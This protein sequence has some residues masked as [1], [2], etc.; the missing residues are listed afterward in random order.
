MNIGGHL[1]TKEGF[2]KL[3]DNAH[4]LGL[5]TYQFFSKNQMQWKARPLDKEE[6]SAHVKAA[7]QAGINDESIHASYLLNLGSPEEDKYK[8]SYGAF[9]EEI[10]RTDQLGVPLLIFHPG[11]HMGSGEENA[12]K[13]ISDAMNTA[14]EETKG[15]KVK[16]TVENTAG[17]GSVVGYSL[18]HLGYI[19]EN[20]VDKNRIG[21]CIDTCHAFQ[22]GYDLSNKFDS[23]LS[24]FDSRVGIELLRAFHL[25]DSKYPFNK[26]LDRHENLG[27]GNISHSFYV[28]LFREPKLAKVPAFLETPEGEEGYPKDLK[29]LK[30]LGIVL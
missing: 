1:S 15:A 17:Q 6:A 11:A 25:N 20:S 12:L 27:K 9:V 10:K 3:P 2:A 14:I 24:E 23:F 13:R 5:K 28:D 29:F 7:K 26:H 4:A 30:S 8:M 19:A 21:F 16:L 18:D 22:A